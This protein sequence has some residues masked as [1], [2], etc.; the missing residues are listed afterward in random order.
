METHRHR[1]A[2]FENITVCFQITTIRFN[3]LSSD[4]LVTLDFECSK[5][6]AVIVSGTLL[7]LGLI[8]L[9]TSACCYRHRWEIRYACLKLTQRGQRYQKIM[10]EPVRYEYDAFVVYDSEDR[11]WVNEQLLPHLERQTSLQNATQR[12]DPEPVRLCVH[13]RDFPP[14]QEIIGNIWNKMEQSR[15]VI[16]VISKNF[17]QSYYCDYE[18]N[19]AR[20]QSVE[21]GRDFDCSSS[22]GMARCG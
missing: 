7:G 22:A 17:S 19:L 11:H 14:G 10:N 5:G 2:E 4:I 6:T 16:L 15:K 9:A 21:Q 20:M 18:T 1:L 8:L 13:E 12:I 3:K